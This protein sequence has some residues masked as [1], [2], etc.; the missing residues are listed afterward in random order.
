MKTEAEMGG[1]Q[2]EPRT[3]GATASWEGQEGS[4]PRGFGGSLPCQALDFRLPASGAAREH[5]LVTVSHLCFH[6][7][8][9]TLTQAPPSR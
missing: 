7:S 9:K 1:V 2:P 5:T 6:S 3:N 4:S 8:H